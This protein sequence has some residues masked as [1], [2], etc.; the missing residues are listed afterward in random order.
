[1]HELGL[2]LVTNSILQ[3]L[4]GFVISEFIINGEARE[5]ICLVASVCLSVCPSV[6]L[7]VCTLPFEP[8]DL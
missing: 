1:M 2:R 3:D 6:R 5:I 8:F 4:D 7:I